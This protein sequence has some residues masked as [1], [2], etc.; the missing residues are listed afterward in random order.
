MCSAKY[1]TVS[2]YARERKKKE[3]DL[4]STEKQNDEQIGN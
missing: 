1:V 4:S 3:K 2:F